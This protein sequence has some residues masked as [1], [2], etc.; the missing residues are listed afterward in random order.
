MVKLFMDFDSTITQE[1]TLMQIYLRLPK[2]IFEEAV[3]ISNEEY[4]QYEEP[5]TKNCYS[6]L[7]Q[8]IKKCKCWEEFLN[9]AVIEIFDYSK[10]I[11]GIEL[12]GMALIEK[13]LMFFGINELTRAVEQIQIRN[14]YNSF[15]NRVNKYNRYILSFN[16]SNYLIG[17]VCQN[18][19]RNNIISNV[20][21]FNKKKFVGFNRTQILLTPEHKFNH[22]NILKDTINISCGDSLSDLLLCLHSDIAFAFKSHDKNFL[23]ICNKISRKFSRNIYLVNDFYDADKILINN[24]TNLLKGF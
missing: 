22:F 23:S 13:C 14:G 7:N 2:E 17:L 16:W 1:S 3:R 9:L 11:E 12:K 8:L 5:L 18:I 4:Y 20:M 19:P 6:N 24:Q 21:D 10:K 15:A